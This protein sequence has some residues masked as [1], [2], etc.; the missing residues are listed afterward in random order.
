[1]G[2]MGEGFVQPELRLHS[3]A[4]S[5]SSFIHVSSHVRILGQVFMGKEVRSYR[6][7]LGIRGAISIQI[8]RDYKAISLFLTDET[9]QQV[10][11]RS[12]TF[13]IMRGT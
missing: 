4:Q 1:M 12:Q 11:P 7:G 3:G 13:P 8:L 2:Q 6:A 9:Q 10:L 5:L